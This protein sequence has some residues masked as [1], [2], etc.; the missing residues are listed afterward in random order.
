M[1]R[2]FMKPAGVLG[3]AC[4][5]A[6]SLSV[7]TARA[8]DA[9]A[10]AAAEGDPTYRP[11]VSERRNGVVLGVAPGVAFAGSSGYPNNAK[12]LNDPA[13]YS[14]SPLLVGSST[15]FFLMGALT[16]WLSIG[17]NVNIASFESASWKSTGAGIGFRV[18]AFPLLR[19][20][21]SLAD[22]SVYTQLGIGT[23]ELRAKGPYPSADGTQSFFGLG[24]H[25]EFR[26][27]RALGGHVSGGPYAEYDVIVSQ[28]VERHWGAV[29]LRVAWYGGTVKLDAR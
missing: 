24:L 16:D 22:T 23:T 13:Y 7:H 3:T 1:A 20:I 27:F 25:H 9:S 6:L 26:W 10:K 11:V 8:E 28:S 18:E 12:L 21:P 2:V 15:S 14:E 29:G 4:A 19:L 17:P 5:I